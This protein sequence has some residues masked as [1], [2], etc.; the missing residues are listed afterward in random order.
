MSGCGLLMIHSQGPPPRRTRTLPAPSALN[1]DYVKLPP[2]S[3]SDKVLVHILEYMILYF[4][5]LQTSANRP[6]TDQVCNTNN[7]TNIYMY[8]CLC[9]VE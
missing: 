4:I 5:T 1:Y 7:I 8:V 9:T 2:L 3:S 6:E